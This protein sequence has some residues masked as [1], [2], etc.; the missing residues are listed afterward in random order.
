VVEMPPDG[1]QTLMPGGVER[2]LRLGPP[3][4]VLL[5]DELLD[6]IQD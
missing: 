3:Q 4:R 6:P 1:G 5:G 2:A